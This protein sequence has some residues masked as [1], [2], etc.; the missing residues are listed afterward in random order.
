MDKMTEKIYN[1]YKDKLD[2]SDLTHS[3][4]FE[5]K[6]AALNKVLAEYYSMLESLKEQEAP[7]H[8]LTIQ[9]AKV[10]AMFAIIADLTVMAIE[11]YLQEQEA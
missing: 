10:N 8:F 1:D 5:I 6:T 11:M 3:V 4:H 7:K 2:L 9:E